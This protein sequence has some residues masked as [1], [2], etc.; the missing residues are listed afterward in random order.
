MVEASALRP[1]TL[2]SLP[3][4]GAVCPYLLAADGGWRAS[5]PAREHRC[6]A[7]VPHIPLVAE[8][9]RRLCLEAE[10]RTCATYQVAARHGDLGAASHSVRPDRAVR[11]GGRALV[12]TAPLVLDHGRLAISVPGVGGDRSVGQAAL[13]LLMAAALVAILIARMSTPPGGAVAGVVGSAA[14]ASPSP[15]ALSPTPFPSLVATRTLVPTPSEPT[16]SPAEAAATGRTADEPK[17]YKV[18]RGDTLSGIAAEFGTTVKK[19]KALNGI[20]DASLLRIGQVLE[21]P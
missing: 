19:L 21:L 18:R 2:P 12:R 15:S 17:S 9:Q 1:V 16:A 14:S 8:K 10:H 20:K 13:V 6:T 5:T 7:V 3:A 4:T 11:V